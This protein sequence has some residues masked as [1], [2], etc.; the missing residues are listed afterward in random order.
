MLDTLCLSLQVWFHPLHPALAPEVSFTIFING[1][2]FFPSFLL[3][4]VNGS[5]C[6]KHMEGESDVDVSSSM[7]VSLPSLDY[8]SLRFS[9][10]VYNSCQALL[11]YS[12][13]Y[14]PASAL[15]LISTSSLSSSSQGML[16]TPY[17]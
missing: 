15:C 8:P 7:I 16:I 11:F 17:C 6:G 5:H 14:R 10:K 13:S 1:V 3:G 12:C 4:L 9:T 2:L